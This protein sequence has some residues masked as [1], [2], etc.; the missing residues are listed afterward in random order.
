VHVATVELGQAEHGGGNY[1]RYTL[2]LRRYYPA[3]GK[4]ILAN[5]LILGT[6]S[7]SVPL[8]ELF[9]LGGPDSLRGYDRD[10]FFG[11]SMASSST[12]LRIPVG[13]GL[14]VVGLFDLGYA[15]GSG[16]VHPAIGAGLRVVTPIGPL[17]IDFAVG[18]R[19]AQTHF[20]AGYVA[21]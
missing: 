13:T 4:K 11:R 20:T 3:G 15:S 2:N 6:S 16:G 9:W 5:R 18:T 10:E 7:G 12:E 14:Q 19:G 1:A 21:F 8:P 17:R